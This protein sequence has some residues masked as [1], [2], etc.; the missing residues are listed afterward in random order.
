[1][2]VKDEQLTIT[3]AEWFTNLFDISDV[4]N[5][6]SNCQA[7]ETSSHSTVWLFYVFAMSYDFVMLCTSTFYLLRYTPPSGRMTRLVKL[8]F[9]DGLGF[10]VILTAVNVFNLILFRT[11]DK[12]TQAS[13]TCLGEALTWIMS[14]K[15]LIHLRDAAADHHRSTQVVSRPPHSPRSVSHAMRS[16]FD[17]KDSTDDEFNLSRTPAPDG[18][19]V[20]DIVRN[21]SDVEL[22]V[23]VQV[24]HSVTV[25]CDPEACP[26]EPY[27]GVVWSG[28]GTP[29]AKEDT[30]C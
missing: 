4:Q 2:L 12:L 8:M 14:Q 6:N 7:A 11:S 17:S 18:L 9:F 5:Y 21:L 27:R 13:G 25:E 29:T 20:T 23:E 1:M 22:D 10:F 28:D 19:S 30:A 3:Q 16:Q 26:N 24:G 15:I